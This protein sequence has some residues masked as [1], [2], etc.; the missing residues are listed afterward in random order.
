MVISSIWT[1]VRNGQTTLYVFPALVGLFLVVFSHRSSTTTST[2][3]MVLFTLLFVIR[4]WVTVILGRRRGTYPWEAWFSFF[5]LTDLLILLLNL[6][7]NTLKFLNSSLGAS[8]AHGSHIK[9]TFDCFAPIKNT[10]NHNYNDSNC[11]MSTNPLGRRSYNN[12]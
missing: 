5:P 12:S 10:M 2:I 7:I 9:L 3:T 8:P 1:F 4:C 6:L 11:F